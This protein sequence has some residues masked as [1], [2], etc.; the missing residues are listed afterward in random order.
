MWVFF[1]SKHSVQLG[2]LYVY[3]TKF[4]HS[5][6]EFLKDMW[7]GG[8]KYDASIFLKLYIVNYFKRKH[9]MF[10]AVKLLAAH[11]QHLFSIFMYK[12]P[13]CWDFVLLFRGMNILNPDFSSFQVNDFDDKSGVRDRYLRT[14]LGFL[15]LKFKIKV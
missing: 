6:K 13:K 1:L 9:L 4:E 7:P 8:I 14:I 10:C 11:F 3:R 12:V 2:Q 15:S 5:M